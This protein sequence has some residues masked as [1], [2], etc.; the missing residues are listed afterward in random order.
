MTE[1]VTLATHEVV[2]YTYPRPPPTDTDKVS[3][4]V[5]RA[6]DGTLSG[7]GYQIQSGRKPTATAMLA[8]AQRRLEDALDEEAVEIPADQRPEIHRQLKETV[9][10][11]RTSALYGLVR[12]K[13]RVILIDRR[14]GIYAQ[15]DYWDG[16][17]RF[18]EMKSYR[19]IPPPREVA[20][21]VRIFQLAFPELISV[22]FCLD[23]HSNP[24]TA[25]TLVVPPPT[26]E[27]R[28]ETLRNALRLGLEY[29]KTAVYEY[30]TVPFTRYSLS[31]GPA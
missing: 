14:V 2:R 3:I 24:V 10:A 28:E 5:G 26:A 9:H 31:P 22:L 23:R 7:F 17:G 12:P 27:E 11:Y 25:S 16:H 30:M 18:F 6:I 13:S 21:Q 19:A 29:G 15:P 20:L 4:A 8:E 1:I